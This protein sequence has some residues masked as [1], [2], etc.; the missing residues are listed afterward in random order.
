MRANDD[1]AL[2]SYTGSHVRLSHPAEFPPPE[3]GS[4]PGWPL[5]LYFHHV[6]PEMRHYT[7]VTP[8]AFDRA[9]GEFGELFQPL[10]PETVPSVLKSGGHPDPVGLVTFDDGYTDVFEHAV[11]IM[12]RRGWRAVMFVSVDLIG[13]VE[14]H[15]VR[16]QLQ[17][18]TWEQLEELTQRGHLV[19]SHGCTHVAFNRLDPAK[20]QAEVDRARHALQ[21]RLPDSPDWLAYPFGELPQPGTLALPSLCFGSIKAPARAWD[22]APQE[23]RR[24]YL[25]AGEPQRWGRCITE[26]RR[27]W[28]HGGSL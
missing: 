1:R 18:M 2:P 14:N 21:E 5:V 9:L 20:A 7:A 10:G 6:H 22:K 24:T 27:T 16:G 28:E 8:A 13:C 25:P 17:H 12:E 15:P 26:W 3:V 19:A 11:P 4:A 23:I